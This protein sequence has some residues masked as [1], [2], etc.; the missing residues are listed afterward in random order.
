MKRVKKYLPFAYYFIGILLTIVLWLWGTSNPESLLFRFNPKDTFISFFDLIGNN[1]FWLS[2]GTT[3]LRLLIGVGIALILGLPL[4]LLIGYFQIFNKISYITFQFLRM[5]SPLSW[6]PIAIILFGIGNYPVIFLVSIAAVWPII[7]NTSASVL[8]VDKH[9]IEVAKGFGAKHWQV[10]KYIII[11]ATLPSVLTGLQL[12]IG[13][14][15][16]VIVPAEMLGV[17]SGLGYLILDYRDINEYSYIMAVILAI[18]F[19][20]VLLDY[21]LRMLIKKIN[22]S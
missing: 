4:G 9:L 8:F 3:F 2:L 1:H 14:A 17:S 22:W 15:W 12:S 6:T 19:L 21:P 5:I 10:I 11:R 7:L 13:V 20:G 18:G 16:L